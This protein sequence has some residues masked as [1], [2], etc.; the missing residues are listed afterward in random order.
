[1]VILE[2][3]RL[4]L[5]HFVPG[6][7]EALFRLYRDPE[8]RRY[9]P[10]GTRTLEETK[11][12][13]EWFRHGHPAHP[14]LGLWATIERESGAFLGRCGL[15]P[16]SIDG[17]QEVELAFLIDK[18]RWREGLATEA[19]VAI[20]EY[21]RSRLRLQRLICLVMPG[22]TASAAIARRVG[23]RFEREYTD[24]FGLCHIYAMELGPQGR[25]SEIYQ[26]RQAMADLA[27]SGQPSEE[28]LVAIATAGYDVVINLAL[29]DDPRYSLKDEAAFVRQLGLEYVHIPVQFGA[30]T[31]ADLVTFFEAMDAYKG[32]RV[33]IHC[34]ANKRVT[35][36]LG[37]FWRLREGCPEDRAFELMD[38]VWEPDSVWSAFIRNQLE[39]PN[40]G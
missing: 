17:T 7:L 27:T 11:E 18:S 21:A 36:F 10:D 31:E 12:E 8:V 34:A 3:A 5:R 23:M 37:L 28:Q 38:D 6:D 2:T 19:S 15:L 35:A 26:Y 16:W 1:M 40:A 14:E 25:L 13:L 4:Q 33:W 32:R 24:N 30:P 29:H 20:T 39:K 9:F 22:N